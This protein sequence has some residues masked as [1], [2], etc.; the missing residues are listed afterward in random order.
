MATAQ[1]D[2]VIQHL[3]RTIL[4]QDGA[5]W[6]DGQLLASFID[7]KD[8]AAFEA[9]VRRH[10]P[11]VF[12]VCHRVVRNH[13]DAEDALQ[14][15]FLVLARKASSVRPRE[16]V[17]NW[18]HGVAL[19][20]AMRAKAMSVKRRGREKQV[21]EMP[22]PA[23]VQ[24]D[25]WSDLRPLLD[26]ELTRLPENYRLPIL[27]CDLEGKKIRVAA[28]QLGWPQGTL[29]GRLALGRKMLAV[30]LA[31]RGVVLS[32]G[33]L[34]AVVSQNAV[35]AAVPNSLI[36]SMVRAAA[37]FAAGQATVAGVVSAKAVALAKGVVLTMLLN[38]IKVLTAVLLVISAFGMVG[39]LLSCQTSAP[40][41][42]RSQPLPLVEKREDAVHKSLPS[43]TEDK[44]VHPNPAPSANGRMYQ[45][46]CEVIEQGDGGEERLAAPTIRTVEGKEANFCVAEEVATG[47]D[48]RIPLARIALS[49]KVKKL[50]DGRLRL[51]VRL[52]RNAPQEAD[53]DELRIEGASVC[54]IKTVREEE[55]VTVEIDGKEKKDR[56]T[57]LQITVSPVKD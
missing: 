4:R 57:R 50:E 14:A 13:H 55:K 43:G 23:T 33:A 25:Q 41:Q 3:R 42:D 46:R 26:Q 44:K 51:N 12:G 27:L 40:A 11:M 53:N 15:T 47:D 30:R 21:M 36:G 6:S 52:E 35:S 10:G 16:Q 32:A 8:E 29:A 22:E 39:G 38:K 49:A 45:F 56:C 17:A 2:A 48:E 37:M 20:I 54:I 24:Q 31:R 34:A 9:L 28:Q 5:G 18:L 19:R 7:Q 1:M